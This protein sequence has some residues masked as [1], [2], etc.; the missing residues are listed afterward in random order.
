MLKKDLECI[1]K[2]SHVFMGGNLIFFFLKIN[3]KQMQEALRRA[4]WKLFLYVLFCASQMFYVNI[5]K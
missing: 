5:E 1:Q 4:N 2:V 3:S